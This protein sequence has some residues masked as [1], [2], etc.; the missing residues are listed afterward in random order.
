MAV[1]T[2][3]FGGATSPDPDRSNG[4]PD[5]GTQAMLDKIGT[6]TSATNVKSLGGARK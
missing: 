1:T 5:T 2:T 3:T 6:P 4:K